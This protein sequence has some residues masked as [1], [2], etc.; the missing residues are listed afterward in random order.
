MQPPYG[1][2]NRLNN[3]FPPDYHY[4]ISRVNLNYGN[5]DGRHHVPPSSGPSWPFFIQLLSS[6]SI[7]MK[8]QSTP[9][10]YLN[11]PRLAKEP[12]T[13]GLETPCKGSLTG[14]SHLPRVRSGS[15]RRCSAQPIPPRPYRP[16]SWGCEI[17][18][19]DLQIAMLA[20]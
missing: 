4:A 20:A 18:R 17:R 11:L 3:T 14:E 13:E 15:V 19:Q 1:R 7:R 9:L 6:R 2:T 8:R 12:R 16:R 5:S 10:E